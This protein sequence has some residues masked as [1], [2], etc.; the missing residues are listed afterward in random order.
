MND[1]MSCTRLLDTM[2][3]TPECVR[4]A[5]VPSLV[6]FNFYSY[7]NKILQSILYGVPSH[8]IEDFV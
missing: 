5:R 4:L 8:S 3:Y 1:I 6:R 2:H 7:G